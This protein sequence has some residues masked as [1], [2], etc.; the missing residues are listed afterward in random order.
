MDWDKGVSEEQT[1]SSEPY[2]NPKSNLL[3][4]RKVRGVP[5]QHTDLRR[6]DPRT[7]PTEERPNQPR[8]VSGKRMGSKAKQQWL[9]QP[10]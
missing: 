9:P 4:G 10:H 3:I 6:N 2:A 1:R 5:K 7:L 8:A